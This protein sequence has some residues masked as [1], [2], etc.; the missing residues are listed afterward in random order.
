MEVRIEGM[1][2]NLAVFNKHLNALE[3]E[4]RNIN[5]RLE[6]RENELREELVVKDMGYKEALDTRFMELSERLAAFENNMKDLIEEDKN[7]PGQTGN[8]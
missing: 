4:G 6:A 2:G 3:E 1:S 7:V 8:Q 5:S